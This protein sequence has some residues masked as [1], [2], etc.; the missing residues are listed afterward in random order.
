MRR[1]YLSA[2]KYKLS[3][4]SENELDTTL[5]NARELTRHRLVNQQ[6]ATTQLKSPTE[7]VG[8]FCAVQ[9]Q[10]YEQT[11]WG[12]GL[13]LPHLRNADIEEDFNK[14]NILR[15]HLL[16]PTWH[17]VTNQDIRWLL[18]LTSAQVHK[19]NA[20]MYRKLELDSKVFNS[21][22]KILEDIL[23]GGNELTRDEINEEFRKNK[24]IA[25]GHRL[26][27]IMMY[28]ELERIICSGARQGRQFSYALFDERVVSLGKA[29]KAER[30]ESLAKLA[31]GYFS[32]RGPASLH[33]FSTW[34]GLTLTECKRGI[35][36]IKDCL[37]TTSVDGAIYDG[38]MYYLASDTGFDK[39]LPKSIHLLP[40]YDEYIMGYKDRSAILEYKYKEALGEDIKFRYDCMIIFDG[41]A[42]GTWRRT[43]KKNQIELEYDLFGA[44]RRE[45]RELFE[46]A[47]NKLELFYGMRAQYD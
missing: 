38:E 40:I 5:M 37:E 21:C 46:T 39:D 35:G 18:E 28:A 27:Y 12:L 41:Q 14:G 6:I 11:K 19:A 8:H 25:Q 16:R 7:M 42:I 10:E 13:R 20:Y 32:S 47:I 29:D 4:N 23:Q 33:D 26:S 30:D 24:I 17:F 3:K 15:T 34:S 36:I 1:N 45:Q 9:G 2:T 43:L 44:R 22:N 31:M